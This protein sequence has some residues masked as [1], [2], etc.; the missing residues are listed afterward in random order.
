VARF[1]EEFIN[2]PRAGEVY[3]L[4]GG[5][6]NACS[7][8]EAFERVERLTGK[9]MKWEYVDKAR[10]G[11]HICYISDLGKMKAH[12]PRWSIEKSLDDIFREIVDGWM[13]RAPAVQPEVAAVD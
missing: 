12:Y 11:D 7:I 9:P 4:G 8:H 6:D 2:A 5:R 1:A 3:N 13:S 10:E